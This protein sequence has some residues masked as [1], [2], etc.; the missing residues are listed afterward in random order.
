ML[1]VE[2]RAGLRNR[3]E[4][5]LNYEAAGIRDGNADLRPAVAGAVTFRSRPLPALCL[6]K[7]GLSKGGQPVQT[8]LTTVGITDYADG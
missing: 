8:G 6:I 7:R 1:R 2:A 3:T 4:G 5:G